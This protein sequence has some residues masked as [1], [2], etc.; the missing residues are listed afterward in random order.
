MKG[1]L[2]YMW[3][4]TEGAKGCDEIG[5][6]R[7]RGSEHVFPVPAS[8]AVSDAARSWEG[9]HCLELLFVSFAFF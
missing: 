9:R 5:A 8:E 3:E 1:D 2:W 7:K 4:L 6:F